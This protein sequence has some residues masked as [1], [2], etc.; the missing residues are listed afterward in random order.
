V[1]ESRYLG[2]YVV[3]LSLA[4]LPEIR[5]PANKTSK[6]MLVPAT[7]LI[8]VI[9]ALGLAR[10][11]ARDIGRKSASR[12][13]WDAASGLQSMGIRAGDRV[14]CVGLSCD[15]GWARLARVSVVAEIPSGWEDE[16]WRASPR[17]RSAVL[18]A[19]AKAGARA[20]VTGRPPRVSAANGWHRLGMTDRY[21]R[22]L[23]SPLQS[24]LARVSTRLLASPPTRWPAGPD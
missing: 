18:R 23:P 5:L 12:A 24:S 6:T 8:L 13:D 15:N 19:F 11:G 10:A 14:G 3:L 9:P 17:V 1:I 22:L 4:L 7:L 20:V 21:V 16:Y 2:A